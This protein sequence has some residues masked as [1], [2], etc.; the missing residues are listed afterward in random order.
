MVS[1]CTKYGIQDKSAKRTFPSHLPDPWAGTVSC[2]DQGEVVCLV[3][4]EKWEKTQRL[5]HEPAK[6]LEDAS[7]RGREGPAV[8]EVM[9]G[10]DGTWSYQ[11]S[12]GGIAAYHQWHV[13]P[14]RRILRQRLLKIR[15]FL[16]Y[17]VRTYPWLNPYTKGL[18]IIIDGWRDDRDPEGWRVHHKGSARLLS[19]RRAHED[20]QKGKGLHGPLI[21]CDEKGPDRVLPMARLRRDAAALVELTS[22]EDPP[23]SSIEEPRICWPSTCQATQAA[24]GS[25]WPLSERI[26]CST[27]PA[28]GRGIGG[29]NPPTSG[30]QT[31]W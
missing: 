5:M 4:K 14:D 2:T 25:A 18:H 28:L 3:S 24:R 20:E 7:Q 1:L 17:V 12:V 16:N 22:T 13:G 23:G 9:Q 31:T 6:M 10:V 11:W 15:G 21:V 27:R 19:F 29:R 30:R 26:G 8:F